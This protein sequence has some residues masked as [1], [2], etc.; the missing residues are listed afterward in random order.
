MSRLITS[1]CSYTQYCW[2]T[3]ADYLGHYYDTHLQ[4]GQAGQD[5]TRI[6]RGIIDS[7]V[8]KEDTVVICWTGFDRFNYLQNQQWNGMGSVLG[9][10]DFF[11]KYYSPVERFA[12]MID[13]MTLLDLHSRAVGY[14]TYHFS[15]FPWLL[16]EI[17]KYPHPD[18]IALSQRRPLSNLY[19]DNDLETFKINNLNIRIKH[20][21][22]NDDDHPT[23]LCHWNWLKQVVLPVLDLKI[24]T[25]IE[26]IVQL[27]QQK[28]LNGDVD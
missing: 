2:P 24:D 21:Y 4:L 6:A 11:T 10:K 28:V 27:N 14:Q 9:Q 17:E 16:G 8:T 25:K 3:W 12:T 23:P 18:N 5:C 7:N 13:A 15:A 26:N 1:G 22:N 19:M 20:Q